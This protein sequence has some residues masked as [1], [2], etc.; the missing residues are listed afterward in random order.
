[1]AAHIQC[2]LH[3][4][5]TDKRACSKIHGISYSQN[6]MVSITDAVVRQIIDILLGTIGPLYQL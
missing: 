5:L 3:K 6:W 4:I 2:L 1:M